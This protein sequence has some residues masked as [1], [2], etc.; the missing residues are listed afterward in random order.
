MKDYRIPQWGCGIIAFIILLLI[1]KIFP[2]IK[3]HLTTEI[4]IMG[5]YTLSFNL[6]YGYAGLLAFGF[7]ALFGIGA[8]TA[9][10]IFSHL[11]GV[12]LLLFMP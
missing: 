12:P 7:G 1:P 5:L 8:Y 9:A 4:L 3:T 10:L 6:L 11:P 2:E